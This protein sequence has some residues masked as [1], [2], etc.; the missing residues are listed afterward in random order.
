MLSDALLGCDPRPLHL[1]PTL[2]PLLTHSLWLNLYQVSFVRDDRNSADQ[3]NIDL[4]R[5]LCSLEPG[6]LLQQRRLP[7]MP[8][9]REYGPQVIPHRGRRDHEK[10]ILSV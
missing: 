1:T 7:H 9:L 8:E 4:R 5:K 6:Q 2:L 3:P 10:M